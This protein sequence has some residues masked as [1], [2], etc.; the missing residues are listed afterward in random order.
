[1]GEKGEISHDWSNWKTKNNNT[2]K[3]ALFGRMNKKLKPIWSKIKELK[4]KGIKWKGV[5]IRRELLVF[6]RDLTEKEY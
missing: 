6:I 2:K 1:M 4:V 5:G 3:G